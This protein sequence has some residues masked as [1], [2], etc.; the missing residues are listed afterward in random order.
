MGVEVDLFDAE[1][2]YRTWEIF[3]W[4]GPSA[5]R[6]SDHSLSFFIRVVDIS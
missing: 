4:G 3:F 2:L 1:D 5:P 6:F